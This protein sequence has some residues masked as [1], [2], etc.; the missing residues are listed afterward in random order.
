[1]LTSGHLTMIFSHLSGGFSIR[2]EG[3]SPQSASM[4]TQ[5][6]LQFPI[7]SGISISVLNCP[8]FELNGLNCPQFQ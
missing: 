3:N 1:M 6:H 4:M 5:G 2:S 8:N 7:F